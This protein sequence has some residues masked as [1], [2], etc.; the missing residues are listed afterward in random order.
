MRSLYPH[1]KLD[2]TI[3][4]LEESTGK[5]PE[6]PAQR[7]ELARCLLSRGLFHQGGE[8]ECNRALTV[9]RKVMQDDPASAE[10][11]VVAERIRDEVARPARIDGAEV[12]VG[13]S[14]GVALTARPDEGTGD[15][16]GRADAAM[17]EAKTRGR[18]RI[19]VDAA[20][21]STGEP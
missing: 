20:P 16:I 14:I 19:V 11:L 15:L 17:Y 6:D 2:W 18:G 7:R 8:A 3:S 12:Q 21:A 5:H 4:R 9:V 1:Q 13:T 10:A